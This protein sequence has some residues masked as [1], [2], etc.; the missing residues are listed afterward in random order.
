MSARALPYPAVP[1]AC[2]ARSPDTAAF[3]Y[4]RHAGARGKT[5]VAA[6]G[7]ERAN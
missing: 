2:G 1:R 6:T 7:V 5:G 3:V 4:Q